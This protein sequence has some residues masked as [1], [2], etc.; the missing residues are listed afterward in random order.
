VP[1]TRSPQ[2]WPW[3]WSVGDALAEAAVLGV[4]T[5]A[6]SVAHPLAGMLDPDLL[7][8]LL[9]RVHAEDA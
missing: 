9:P 1:V 6:A 7:A 8:R 3:P 5:A 4:A 2:G